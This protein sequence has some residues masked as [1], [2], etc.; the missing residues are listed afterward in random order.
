[1]DGMLVVATCLS[2]HDLIGETAKYGG[3]DRSSSD[4]DEYQHRLNP[5]SAPG[6]RPP[7]SIRGKIVTAAAIPPRQK[8]PEVTRTFVLFQCLTPYSSLLRHALVFLDFKPFF[9]QTGGATGRL[10]E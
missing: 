6:L 2:S 7:A 10:I 3:F 5:G 1:M 9:W 8:D 4:S